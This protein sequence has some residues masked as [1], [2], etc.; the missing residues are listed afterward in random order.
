MAVGANGAAGSRGSGAGEYGGVCDG[1]VFSGNAAPGADTDVGSDTEEA[2]DVVAARGGG[3]TAG[4]ARQACDSAR[5]AAFSLSRKVLA[6]GP[7][8]APATASAPE[9][10]PAPDRASGGDGWDS[11]SSRPR[12][13][14]DGAVDG[15]EATIDACGALERLVAR[16]VGVDGAR[17]E[18]IHKTYLLLY[19]QYVDDR[20]VIRIA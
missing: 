13:G 6:R 17:G 15:G 7:C 20:S 14:R 4:V 11:G 2:P 19:E 8:T 9:A 18:D 10:A 16:G 1:G 3:A 12:H 5:A